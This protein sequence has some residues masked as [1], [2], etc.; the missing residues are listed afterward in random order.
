M[1]DPDSPPRGRV[2]VRLLVALAALLLAW[3]TDPVDYEPRSSG[4]DAGGSPRA[5]DG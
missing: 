1:Q 2:L 3:F 4:L 5:V